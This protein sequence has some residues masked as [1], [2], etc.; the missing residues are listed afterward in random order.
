MVVKLTAQPQLLIYTSSKYLAQQHE[1]RLAV[2]FSVH[3][4]HG[5]QVRLSCSLRTPIDHILDRTAAQNTQIDDGAENITP[6]SIG[7][8][9]YATVPDRAATCVEVR[10]YSPTEILNNVDAQLAYA[11]T[12]VKN[13]DKIK[14]AYGVMI[15]KLAR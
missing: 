11:V 5:L 10:Y 3:L 2:F 13:A 1:A 15:A 6:V 8:V 14:R 9:I 12:D 4:R 7:L